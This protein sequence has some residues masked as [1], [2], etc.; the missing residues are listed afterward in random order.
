MN[1]PI[2]NYCFAY[3]YL[4]PVLTHLLS[5]NAA[6]NNYN[7]E[8]SSYIENKSVNPSPH[9]LFLHNLCMWLS[10]ETPCDSL[11]SFLHHLNEN[12]KLDERS[13]AQ[14]RVQMQ[15]VEQTEAQLNKERARLQ[16]ML[17]HLQKAASMSTSLQTNGISGSSWAYNSPNFISPTSVSS[18]RLNPVDYLTLA[19]VAAS[20]SAGATTVAPSAVN[21][22]QNFLTLGVSPLVEAVNLNG[23]AQNSPSS[24]SFTPSI[25]M[26]E[27][28]SATSASK[29]ASSETLS[30]PANIWA[31]IVKSEASA[32]EKL[33]ENLPVGRFILN[34]GFLFPARS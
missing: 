6:I 23:H 24:Q 25:P 22:F 17:Q 10:C 21:N 9:P 12:H 5:G 29:L 14:C 26:T 20:R 31:D 18:P 11:T 15:V 3:L 19:N 28:S 32:S 4:L 8:L 30:T 7:K 2:N 27:K 1:H 34:F 16:A 33:T 13:T